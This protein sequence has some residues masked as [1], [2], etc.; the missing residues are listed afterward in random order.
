MKLFA[1]AP[2]QEKMRAIQMLSVLDVP[3]ANK[4]QQMK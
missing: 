1:K 2:P 4:Y 3:N